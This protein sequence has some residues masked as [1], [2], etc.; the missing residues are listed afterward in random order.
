MNH[1]G[2]PLDTGARTR[3]WVAAKRLQARGRIDDR[4]TSARLDRDVLAL[5]ALA[6]IAAIG[7]ALYVMRGPAFSPLGI[8]RLVDSDG[9]APGS[10]LAPEGGGPIATTRLL[11]AAMLAVGGPHALV[12]QVALA[13]SVAACAGLLFFLVRPRVGPVLAL[14][15]AVLTLLLGLT[16]ELLDTD[17]LP[18]VMATAF[19]LGGLLAVERDRNGLGCGLLIIA[20]SSSG[21]GLSFAAAAAVLLPRRALWVVGVPTALLLLWALWATGESGAGIDG[22]GILRV[23]SYAANAVAAATAAI[24]GF[25][26]AFPEGAGSNDGLA[27]GQVLAP[28][29]A[30]LVIW[31]AVRGGFTGALASALVLVAGVCVALAAGLDP[32]QGSVVER[33]A[34]PLAIALILLLAESFRG[35]ATTRGAALIAVVAILVA[36]PPNLFAI[37]DTA[38]VARAEAD[39]DGARLAALELVAAD[40]DPGYRYDPA[41]PEAARYLELVAEQGSAAPPVSELPGASPFARGAAD[42]VLIDAL[43]PAAVSVPAGTPRED[44][45]DAP[46]TGG[47][48]TFP[49]PA[50][51][52][53]I[54]SD[55]AA[56]LAVSRF[57]DGVVQLP[58]ALDPDR[59]ALLSF[60]ADS[61]TQPWS[62]TVYTASP[63]IRLC[64]PVGGGS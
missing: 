27:W 2:E 44:C 64:E 53:V 46:A 18:V 12:L 58:G 14:A 28:I 62:V 22:V 34:F 36:L 20:V 57:G 63:D 19:G 32:L 38:S 40:V 33:G 48:V 55:D 13:V 26:N 3:A 29:V 10:I 25:T 31:R 37:R 51:G 24:S 17:A 23:P 52:V 49:L 4:V 41:A 11:I 8:T 39:A 9:F 60:P 16:R 47:A 42:E 30:G 35:T 6:T 7:L 21:V 61:S 5:L 56:G 59:P 45:L 50:E 1:H 43:S 15:A 54:A